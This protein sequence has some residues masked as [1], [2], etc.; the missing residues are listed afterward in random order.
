M[1]ST[2][3]AWA[4]DGLTATRSD[5][6]KVRIANREVIT[7]DFSAVHPLPDCARSLSDFLDE[8]EEL[9]DVSPH[10]VA[11]RKEVA[12]SLARDGRTRLSYLRLS[13]GLSQV[14]LARRMK[15]SQSAISMLERRLQK[16]N[17]ETIRGLAAAL[18]VDFNSLMDAL[19]GE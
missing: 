9:P 17:E 5:G 8:F 13:K 7:L 18:E 2:S 6:G 14:E 19:A 11:A 16:P 15:T 1:T 12:D 3:L 4:P 10:V